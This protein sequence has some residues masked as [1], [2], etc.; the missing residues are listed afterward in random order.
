MAHLELDSA[1]WLYMRKCSKYSGPLEQVT[2]DCRVSADL[3]VSGQAEIPDRL[4][5]TGDDKGEVD[6]AMEEIER[7]VEHCQQSVCVRKLPTQTDAVYQNV[8]QHVNDVVT[9]AQISLGG[10]A[11]IRLIGTAVEVDDA[12]KRLREMCGVV[13]DDQAV[14]EQEQGAA[15]GHSQAASRNVQIM[16]LET[17]L[18]KYMQKNPEFAD[19]VRRLKE[20]MHVDVVEAVSGGQQSEAEVELVFSGPDDDVTAAMDRTVLLT[21]R[22][23][24][25]TTIKSFPC[26]DNRVFA[27]VVRL[28]PTINRNQGLVSAVD[29]V[30]SITGNE[31]E[32]AVCRD[33]LVRVGLVIEDQPKRSTGVVTVTDVP[34]PPTPPVA[35]PPGVAEAR[36]EVPPTA[37][38]LTQVPRPFDRAVVQ[39]PLPQLPA[40][41]TAAAA[42]A[43][44]QR[45]VD[46]FSAAGDG[47]RRGQDDASA[48]SAE[49]PVPIEAPLWV[50]IEKRRRQQLQELRDVY[51]V[52]VQSYQ[53][54]DGMVRIRL[55]ATS[56][57]MLACGQDALG[58]LIDQLNKSVTIV[59]METSASQDLPRE[60]AL[61]FEQLAED[62]DAIIEV[63]GSRIIFIGSTDGVAACQQK[64]VQLQVLTL[65]I[66]CIRHAN[67]V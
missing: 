30:V 43:D 17:D 32:Q 7:M 60:A 66:L 22:C 58:Q 67:G 40:D 41:P 59:P 33:K 51:G 3:D 62:T 46:P 29:G 53:S 36:A 55:D 38:D 4:I 25:T 37:I 20:E 8:V 2:K 31:E 14:E 9:G 27:K 50:F 42:A 18:W 65:Y 39:P 24:A 23:R 21:S 34:P 56:P 10:P 13:E 19:D 12:M 57:D 49:L 16:K 11:N 26:D 63:A 47:W 52:S 44:Q 64:I 1:V 45:I 54:D 28:L 35:V 15:A 6:K 61:V 48:T 5:L